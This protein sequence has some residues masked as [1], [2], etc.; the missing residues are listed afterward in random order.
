MSRNIN[1]IPSSLFDPD[2]KVFWFFT[3]VLNSTLKEA[4]ELCTGS[5]KNNDT[6]LVVR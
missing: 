6:T 3:I 1:L 5:R 4:A 2:A